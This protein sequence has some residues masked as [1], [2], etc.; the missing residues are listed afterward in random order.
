MNKDTKAFIA[1]Y[2]QKKHLK[3]P[4]WLSENRSASKHTTLAAYSFQP[5]TRVTKVVGVSKNIRILSTHNADNDK[6]TTKYQ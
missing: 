1:D 2:K 6:N 3:E 4:H 5:H